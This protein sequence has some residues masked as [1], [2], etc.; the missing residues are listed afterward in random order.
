MS[1]MKMPA[2]TKRS[3]ENGSDERGEKKGRGKKDMDEQIMDML[4]TLQIAHITNDRETRENSGA[5]RTVALI[6][7]TA[8]GDFP[9]WV[10]DGI[11]ENEEW[12]KEMR[13]RPGEN[14][15]SPH[16]RVC[17]TTLLALFTSEEA[18]K[19]EQPLKGLKEWWKVMT[20]DGKAKENEVAAEIKIFKIRG[21]PKK[22][23]GSIEDEEEMDWNSAASTASGKG[24][25]KKTYARMEFMM[26]NREAQ[27]AIRGL[28]E[29]MGAE[30]KNGPAP[31]LQ[32]TRRVKED[33][34]ALQKMGYGKGKQ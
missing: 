10:K 30:I 22:G 33:L 18:Q 21:P 5:L 1:D 27:V 28:L 8:R 7:A 19:F 6:H 29:L 3:R 14:I 23:N 2:W 34:K 24:P 11:E 31:C 13:E 4:A 12:M 26:E 32:P 17:L 25:T 20:K 9:K 16:V 15:G